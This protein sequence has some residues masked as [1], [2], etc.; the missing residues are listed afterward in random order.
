MFEGPQST[1]VQGTSPEDDLLDPR[2]KI[3][4]KKAWILTGQLDKA[5]NAMSEENL[6]FKIVF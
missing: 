4:I 6:S 2:S 5:K 1:K 3:I